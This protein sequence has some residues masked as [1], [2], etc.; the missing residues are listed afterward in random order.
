LLFNNCEFVQNRNA[1]WQAEACVICGGGLKVTT[2][3]AGDA[4]MAYE[5]T[6]DH[7]SMAGVEDE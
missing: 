5:F 2:L 4:R 7:P 3:A 6:P 1:T